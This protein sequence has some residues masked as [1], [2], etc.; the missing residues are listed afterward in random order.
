MKFG[1]IVTA[2]TLMLV[3]TLLTLT[4]CGIHMPSN[5]DASVSVLHSIFGVY[6]GNALS[7]HNAI[8]ND[9]I[10][11]EVF[12]SFNTALLGGAAIIY[13][14]MLILGTI[15]TA[16][17]GIFLGKKW[18]KTFVPLRAIFGV[19]LIVP[20]GN[21]GF[22]IA[23][24]VIYLMA[25]TGIAIANAV[26]MPIAP[27]TASGAASHKAAGIPLA[28]QGVILQ[29]MEEI[30]FNQSI[31]NM[32][33]STT[34][35]PSIPTIKP[36]SN[37]IIIPF[38]QPSTSANLDWFKG[39]WAATFD[40]N[41]IAACSQA[42][43]APPSQA[44]CSTV[45]NQIKANTTQSNPSGEAIYPAR[46]SMLVNLSNK[47][48]KS[49]GKTYTSSTGEMLQTRVK[50]TIAK[51]T[52]IENPTNYMFYQVASNTS[53]YKPVIDARTL[54]TTTQKSL[55]SSATSGSSLN[56]ILAGKINT[57]LGQDG[58]GGSIS[59]DSILAEIADGATP[60]NPHG[61]HLIPLNPAGGSG[62]I[63]D[64]SASWWNAGNEYL[65][66]DLQFAQAAKRID[67]AA[68]QFKI[69]AGK[70]YQQK[71]V[72]HNASFNI[73]FQ[74]IQLDSASV[75]HKHVSPIVKPAYVKA[76]AQRSFPYTGET[77]F[78]ASQNNVVTYATALAKQAKTWPNTNHQ[79]DAAL[80]L[81][82]KLGAPGVCSLVS[83][84][85]DDQ[86]GAGPHAY[87]NLTSGPFPDIIS[88]LQFYF[89][90]RKWLHDS[91]HLVAKNGAAI[92]EFDPAQIKALDTYLTFVYQ[93]AIS[94]HN[95]PTGSS[96]SYNPFVIAGE[97]SP[98]NNTMGFLFSGLI[99][100]QYGSQHIGGLMQQVWCVGIENDLKDCPYT[101]NTPTTNPVI[102]NP[103]NPTLA[104][105][106]TYNMILPG[107]NKTTANSIPIKPKDQ[108]LVAD[109]FDIIRNT[110]LVGLNLI[111]GSVDALT[112]IFQNFSANVAALTA[113]AK[114]KNWGV[115]SIIGLSAMGPIGSA[116]LK[117][118]TVSTQASAT[119]AIAELSVDLM[120]LPVIFVVLTT[121]F[122]TGIMFAI[123][124]PIT[125]YILFWSGKIAWLLLVLEALVAAPIMGLAIAYPDGHDI[126]GM[127]ENGFKTSLNLLLLPVLIII[128]LI[129]SMA[130]TYVV[131]HFS[132]VG[133][134][135]VS[136][137]LL[138]VVSQSAQDANI[139]LTKTVNGHAVD[140][141]S[142]IVQ[143]I[144]ATFIIFMYATFISMA[145]NKCFS[146]I[147]IIPEKVMGWIGAQ[148]AKFGE[149]DAEKMSQSTNQLAEKAGQAGGQTVSQGT[150]AETQ[151]GNAQ[152]SQNAQVQQADIGI[153]EAG[154]GE[155]AALGNAAMGGQ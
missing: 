103:G 147:Y 10:F 152:V 53:T 66:L 40:S 102:P 56:D 133:F 126:W 23:Q 113:N 67:G 89:G 114:A 20:I 48:P 112:K 24:W 150:Q 130:L 58:T 95:S 19:L 22:C 109:H 54:S 120:W 86:Y 100:S 3:V 139:N 78:P 15:Y 4:G 119:I 79:K 149:K 92:P 142:L 51:N 16:Q 50:Y 74:A 97:N 37:S 39:P 83:T 138:Q 96:G 115:G 116:I 7:T 93:L 9:I 125:P 153:G 6:L 143:G 124:I 127:A 70:A 145:F 73:Q 151:L 65:T 28:A 33:N 26:W 68:D 36:G 29:G 98:M 131:I 52:S 80:D 72:I 148:G 5:T 1:K 38:S 82:C 64:A 121:L 69:S 81:A 62:T 122:V 43:G 146:T 55:L 140:Q 106:S 135:W 11:S 41:F 31:T 134:H 63:P 46:L 59:Y 30:F 90:F 105:S 111:S 35:Y 132:A 117:H 13:A 108:G 107:A 60:I 57:Y 44:T 17:D 2:K 42:T 123:L 94:N 49:D 99:G 104:K 85:Y 118:H 136:E 71:E 47:R 110:Q 77:T 34:T 101:Q 129:S 18:G 144:M 45:V 155:T 128:G 88:H 21:A 141:N 32:I 27:N 12:K 14:F 8:A 76:T 84:T 75:P 91:G 25:F 87:T 137:S 154:V 61:D